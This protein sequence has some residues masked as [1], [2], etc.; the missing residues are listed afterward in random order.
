M[1]RAFND[2]W[3]EDVI[4]GIVVLSFVTVAWVCVYKM[5]T[6]VPNHQC[7]SEIHATRSDLMVASWYGPGFHGR[8]TASGER[9]DS[10]AFTAAS[11]N[12]PFGTRLLVGLNG[13]WIEIRITDRGPVDTKRDL[14]L[15]EGAAK[16][17]GFREAGVV[18]VTVIKL[19]K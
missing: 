5:A 15:S 19:E 12:L 8:T 17:L 16:A 9:F 11:R 4:Y 13:K 14:D 7:V 1:P 10:E 2:P 6:D 3:F 18:V